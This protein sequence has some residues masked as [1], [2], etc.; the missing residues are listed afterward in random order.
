LKA[1]LR[2]FLRTSAVLA[3][4]L[5]TIIAAPQ[6]AAKVTLPHGSVT[7]PRS[8]T[9]LYLNSDP[10]DYVGGGIEQLYTSAD[11]TFNHTYFPPG[12]DLL[13]VWLEQGG[14]VHWWVVD[15]AAPVGQALAIGSYN[16]AVVS[17]FRTETT[18]GLDVVGDG[19]A[20]GTLTGRFDVE[21]I[22]RYDTGDLRVFQATF[23]SHCEGAAAG[24]YGRIRIEDGPPLSESVSIDTH[25]AVD[26]KTGVAT[27]TGT[28]WCSEALAIDLTVGLFQGIANRPVVFG[29]STTHFDCVAPYSTWSATVIPD[30]GAFQS[31]N[32]Y[33]SVNASSGGVGFYISPDPLVVHLDAG[34]QAD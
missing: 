19:R 4:L 30:S 29:L 13:R 10:G 32:V 6:A 14:Y 27:V 12:T 34:N 15:I 17:S 26:N 24:L 5:G 1:N 2:C 18:P 22:S 28:V 3:V 11:S 9:F 31:G 21:E 25:G 16:G 8:G 20:C 23:E 33:A 7:V